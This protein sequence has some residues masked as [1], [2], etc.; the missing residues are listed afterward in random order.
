M[1]A[2]QGSTCSLGE[3]AHTTSSRRETLPIGRHVATIHLKILLFAYLRVSQLYSTLL[4]PVAT[5]NG[6]F[7]AQP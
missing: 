7:V 4:V 2:G 3:R 5:V 1:M 6:T